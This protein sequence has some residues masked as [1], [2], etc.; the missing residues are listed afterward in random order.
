[1]VTY[2]LSACSFTAGQLERVQAQALFQFL[3]AIGYLQKTSRALVHGPI[4]FGGYNIPHLYAIHGAQKIITVINHIRANTDLGKTFVIN[5][6]I[7]QLTSGR[8]TQF[9]S[10]ENPL[11]Y[12]PDNWLLHLKNS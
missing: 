7:L 6:N 8:S 11:S 2:C 1:M 4:E 5:I 3:P 9:L 10:V 12:I